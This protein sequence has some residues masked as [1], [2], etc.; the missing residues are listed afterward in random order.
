MKVGNKTELKNNDNKNKDQIPAEPIITYPRKRTRSSEYQK[1]LKPSVESKTQTLKVD[2]IGHK[3]HQNGK[4]Q[5][6]SSLNLQTLK[7][8]HFQSDSGHNKGKQRLTS[9]PMNMF[10]AS[11]IKDNSIVLQN[12]YRDRSATAPSAINLDL[13]E[14][15]QQQREFSVMQLKTSVGSRGSV[16]PRMHAFQ[17]KPKK[18]KPALIGTKRKRTRPSCDVSF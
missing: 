6:S 17:Q 10:L 1:H 15:E 3:Q 14:K 11:V 18:Q 5:L 2:P 9:S 8:N 13:E 7:V 16:D 4:M 12:P